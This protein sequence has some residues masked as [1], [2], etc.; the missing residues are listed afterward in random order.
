MLIRLRNELVTEMILAP[1]VGVD[2]DNYTVA[3]SHAIPAGA[4]EIEDAGRRF[5][6]DAGP[7]LSVPEATRA[8]KKL[9]QEHEANLVA[10]G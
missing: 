9:A 10:L 6:A 3:W 2:S 7:K 4:R 8:F 5:Y 1:I